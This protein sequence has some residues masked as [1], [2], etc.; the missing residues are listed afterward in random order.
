M[1]FPTEIKLSA[2]QPDLV[3]LPLSTLA[4]SHLDCFLHPHSKIPSL[5]LLMLLLV[6][7]LFFYLNPAHSLK[8]GSHAAFSKKFSLAPS[9][10][11]MLAFSGSILLVILA[12]FLP[13][14]VGE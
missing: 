11:E 3:P 9:Q 13:L 1:V 4:F 10:G 2:W 14:P 7:A 5:P 6:L 12:R 8:P